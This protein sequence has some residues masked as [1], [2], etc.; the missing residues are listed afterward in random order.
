MPTT[1]ILA[2]V[3]PTVALED[4]PPRQIVSELDKYVVGQRDGQAGRGDRAAQ[5]LA[6]AAAPAEMAEEIAPKNILMIGP[7][8]VGK[9]EIARRL[10]RSPGRRSSRSRRASSPRSA[11]SAA[12]SSRWSA[13][14]SSS[15]SRWCAR[16]KRGGAR[17]RPSATPREADRPPAGGARGACERVEQGGIVFLDELDKIAGSEASSGPDVS[18]EGVQ[19]DLLPIVEGTTVQTRYGRCRPTTSCSSPPAPSTSPSRPT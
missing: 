2:A 5:P 3:A 15:P 13:T 4:M 12:T 9:T 18:G 14:C 10:A 8:G 11:T 17:R 6:A 1:E 7:T 16:R 19:R